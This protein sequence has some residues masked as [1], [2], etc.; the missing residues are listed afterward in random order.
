MFGV[1]GSPWRLVVG[2]VGGILSNPS[3]CEWM[4]GLMN[5][6]S[7]ICAIPR[8]ERVR[9]VL[10]VYRLGCSLLLFSCLDLF[11]EGSFLFYFGTWGR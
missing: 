8:W 4:E 5:K 6:S 10:E 1:L 2:G 9:M 3:D 11:F 7:C